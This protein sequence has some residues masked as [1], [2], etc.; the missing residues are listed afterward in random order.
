MC[1]VDIFNM[2]HNNFSEESICVLCKQNDG[3]RLAKLTQKGCDTLI[4]QSKTKGTFPKEK[5]GFFKRKH[6]C[7]EIFLKIM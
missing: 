7:G 6:M 2:L 4:A 3:R 1:Y 5:I